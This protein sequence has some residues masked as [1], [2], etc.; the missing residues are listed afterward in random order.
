MFNALGEPRAASM[1]HNCMD[2]IQGIFDIIEVLIL[3]LS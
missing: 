3:F 2:H 1:E